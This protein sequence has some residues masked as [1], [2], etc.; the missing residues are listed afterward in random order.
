MVPIITSTTSF[1]LS[2]LS[3][4]QEL[5]CKILPSEGSRRG[6]IFLGAGDEKIPNQGQITPQMVVESGALAKVPFAAARVRKPLLS[7][8]ACNRKGNPGWFDG[9][10]SYLLPHDAEEL[11][12]IRR[13]IAKVQSKIKLHLSNGVYKMKTWRKPAGPFQGPGW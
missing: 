11:P 3:K 10:R 9:E 5:G 6:Q 13:L 1:I 12:E 8:S 4:I 7:V 2:P